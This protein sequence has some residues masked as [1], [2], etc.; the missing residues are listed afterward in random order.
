MEVPMMRR[1]TIWPC[2]SFAVMAIMLAADGAVVDAQVPVTIQAR[3]FSGSIAGPMG[4]RFESST[5][6]G[7]GVSMYFGPRV[8]VYFTRY[9]MVNACASDACFG[10]ADL[11]GEY[12]TLGA[13]FHP[14]SFQR[15]DPWVELGIQNVRFDLVGTD[16]YGRSFNLKVPSAGVYGGRPSGA[17]GV[18]VRVLP[19]LTVA[20]F[21]IASR[22]A[23]EGPDVGQSESDY[24]GPLYYFRR[25]ANPERVS[26]TG[27]SGS[28]YGYGVSISIGTASKR[29]RRDP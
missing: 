10:T 6:T 2:V 19:W 28:L 23:V 1:T 24:P 18:D 12:L 7:F 3:A 14:F 29:P 5:S 25:I 4:E 11:Q 8:A 26:E 16:P 27:T 13:R 21:F 17:L 15:I 20:P 22:Y 9:R